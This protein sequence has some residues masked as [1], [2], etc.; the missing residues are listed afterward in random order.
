DQAGI[1]GLARDDQL[2]AGWSCRIGHQP[3]PTN[4][5]I[6]IRSPSAR[7]VLAYIDF[8]TISRFRSTATPFSGIPRFA[9]KSATVTAS[10]TLA[11][12]PLRNKFISSSQAFDPARD[13]PIHSPAAMRILRV[14]NR[15]QVK[16][17]Q[18]SQS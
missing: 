10:G 9:R 7:R 15:F 4:C 16:A 17:Y 8:G 3:P 14:A 2:V 5:T 11:G 6:S 1:I 18:V 12:S 13:S